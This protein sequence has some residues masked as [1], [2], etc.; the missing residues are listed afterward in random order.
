MARGVWGTVGTEDFT[1]ES[2]SNDDDDPEDNSQH[3]MLIYFTF[4]FRECLDLFRA[5]ICLR[6]CSS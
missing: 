5:P 6:T 3:K 2:L 1:F 4:E